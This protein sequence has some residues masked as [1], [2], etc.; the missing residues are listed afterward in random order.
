MAPTT[1]IFIVLLAVLV[2]ALL[3]V[4]LISNKV[5]SKKGLTPDQLAVENPPV[6]QSG[7]GYVRFQPDNQRYVFRTQEQQRIVDEYFIIRKRYK[8]NWILIS[9]GIAAIVVGIFFISFN[10]SG[11]LNGSSEYRTLSTAWI[12]VSSLI[13]VAGIVLIILGNFKMAQPKIMTDTEYDGLVEL[14]VQKYNPVEIALKVFSLPE[15]TPHIVTVTP[16]ISGTSLLNYT[17]NQDRLRSSELTVSVVLFADKLYIYKYNF[18][19]CCNEESEYSCA[20]DRANICGVSSSARSYVQSAVSFNFIYTEC[21]MAVDAHGLTVAL[22]LTEGDYENTVGA[23]RNF[24][25]GAQA[26]GQER[27]SIS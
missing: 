23:V 26:A 13:G 10:A 19:M 12:V 18:D 5:K 6:T 16:V 17:P 3:V 2:I 21:Q 22:P 25:Y 14:A 15:G 11:G 24:V 8:K 1:I 4:P 20:I 7:I 27:D 9:L